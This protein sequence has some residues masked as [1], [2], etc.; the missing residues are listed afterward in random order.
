MS[1][2]LHHQHPVRSFFSATPVFSTTPV[3]SATPGGQGIVLSR[4]RKIEAAPGGRFTVDSQYGKGITA[5]ISLQTHMEYA[6]C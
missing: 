1:R 6:P 3:F 5:T 4:Y 2:A